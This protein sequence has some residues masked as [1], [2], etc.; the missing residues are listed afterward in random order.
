MLG[1]CAKMQLAAV[2]R[3]AARAGARASPG[4]VP[5]AADIA[6][7]HPAAILVFP[8]LLVDT[9]NGLDTLIRLSNVSD[10]AIDVYCFYVNATPT[11]RIPEASCFPNQLSC[12]A[13]VG[14]QIFVGSASHNWQ[15]NDFIFRLT[16]DQPTGW[17]V[18]QGQ[19]T[20]CPFLDGVCSNDGTTTCR[21]N[22]ECG[23]G[24]HCVL[25]PCFPLDATSVGR[26]RVDDERRRR[27]RCRRKT[28]SSA[29]SSA[30]RSTRTGSRSRATT[31][32][33]MRL[34]GKQYSARAGNAWSSSATTPWASRRFRARAIETR[35]WC[36]A[37]RPTPRSTK[38]ART[39]SILD[40][41][42][43]G[44]VD[45]V[46]NNVCGSNG[47]TPAAS[48]A[49]RASTDAGLPRPT[50]V[51]DGT[52]YGLAGAP[53]A[54]DADCQNTCDLASNTCTLTDTHCA[55]DDECVSSDY[56]V[57]LATDLTLI[58]CTQDFAGVRESGSVEDGGAV[59]GVQRVRAA[60][61]DQ[62]HRSTASMRSCSRT[63]RRTTTRARSSAPTSRAPLTGQS[64]IRGVVNED[65]VG[66]GGNTLIGVAEEFRCA[67]PKYQFPNFAGRW[68]T[69]ARHGLS[70]AG[71]N[72]HFQGRR[73]PRCRFHLEF[74]E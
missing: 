49:L 16:Q 39:F 34:I 67:G 63:W 5:L 65:N 61:L 1:R 64:R 19:S 69:R 20:N 57:R 50:A 72:L 36:S 47:P 29:S 42:F 66:I 4:A 33:A 52:C 53:C 18:S 62:P 8:K 60:L 23:A 70:G 17:L 10:T 46:L 9:A 71:K 13:T 55:S 59:P 27:F 73:T 3:G 35:R 28:R 25:P 44:A 30:S 45:P 26:R 11:A 56:E 21:R 15:P 37:A 58:P 22:A 2:R 48:P 40:H 7:D 24:N 54:C 43:D 14:G 6:S 51:S 41:F 68:W 12:Q 31:S 38:A 32:S 74:A